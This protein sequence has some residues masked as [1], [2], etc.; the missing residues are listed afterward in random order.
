M[1]YGE[2][3]TRP[4]RLLTWLTSPSGSGRRV[5]RLVVPA[6]DGVGP[7]PAADPA[8]E[9]RPHRPRLAPEEFRCGCGELRESCVRRVVRA[10]WSPVEPAGRAC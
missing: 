2:L 4:V 10:I 6:G 1:K 8:R 9:P 7:E 5:G 3:S